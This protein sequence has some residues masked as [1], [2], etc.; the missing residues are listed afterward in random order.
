MWGSKIYGQLDGF[1]G[2]VYEEYCSP[3]P[4]ELE[5]KAVDILA[6]LNRS[7]ITLES[8]EFLVFGG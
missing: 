5:N 7:C 1:F 8:G 6:S 4:L 2:G 3:V